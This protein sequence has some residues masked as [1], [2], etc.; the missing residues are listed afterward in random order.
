[1]VKEEIGFCPKKEKDVA[2]AICYIAREADKNRLLAHADKTW[3]FE[4]RERKNK[5]SLEH[6]DDCPIYVGA[7]DCIDLE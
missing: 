7:P 1:M 5:T 3:C 2:I 6:C 4:C